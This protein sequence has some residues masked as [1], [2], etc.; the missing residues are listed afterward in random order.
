METEYLSTSLRET[1]ARFY[2]EPD[3]SSPR[4]LPNPAKSHVN[5]LLRTSFQR[6]FP[7][8]KLSIPCRMWLCL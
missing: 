5:L 4:P 2:P 8:P 1:S 6:I 3:Q 7:C